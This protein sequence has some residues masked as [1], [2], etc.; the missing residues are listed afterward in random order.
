MKNNDKEQ[1]GMSKLLV[2]S[3]HIFLVIDQALSYEAVDTHAGY[4]LVPNVF[5]FE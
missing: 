1:S 4:C 3:K 2:T 5:I